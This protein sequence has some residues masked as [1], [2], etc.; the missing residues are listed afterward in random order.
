MSRIG[1]LIGTVQVGVS[2]SVP[3]ISEPIQAN[4]PAITNEYGGR[5]VIAAGATH[6]FALEGITKVVLF[7]ASFYDESTGAKK[8]VDVDFNGLGNLPDTT[9][10]IYVGDNIA[11]GITGIAV[12]VPAGNDT[13][14]RYVIAGV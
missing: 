4:T 7:K 11:G 13:E 1:S 14:C 2:G 9:D 5:V 8:G 6:T 3:A 12:T 10:A